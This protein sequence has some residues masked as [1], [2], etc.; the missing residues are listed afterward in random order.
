[1]GGLSN[2]GALTYGTPEEVEKECRE[3]LDTVGR[4]NLIVGADCSLPFS[5]MENLQAVA[6]VCKEY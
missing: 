5:P 1:M 4:D 2:V 3:L 6:R